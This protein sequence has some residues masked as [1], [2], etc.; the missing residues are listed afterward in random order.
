MNSFSGKL[1][2][3]GMNYKL[4]WFHADTGRMFKDQCLV[5]DLGSIVKPAITPD[6]IK[7][8]FDILSDKIKK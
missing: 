2:I 6:D 4:W 1:K 8:V 3:W 7:Q 5:I